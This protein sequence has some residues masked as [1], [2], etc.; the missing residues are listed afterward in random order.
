MPARAQRSRRRDGSA[1]G[2]M[3]TLTILFGTTTTFF[4]ARPS[5]ARTTPSSASTALSISAS[6][7]DAEMVSSAACLPLT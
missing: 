1:R 4:G 3:T 7:A 2:Q 6:P 5:S